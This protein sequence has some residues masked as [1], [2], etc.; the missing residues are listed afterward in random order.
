MRMNQ[1]I[2]AASRRA[3]FKGQT[4]YVVFGSMG[5]ERR[6]YHVAT[7]EELST[8]FAG[9]RPLAVCDHDGHVEFTASAEIARSTG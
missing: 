5:N 3:H 1:A 4:H 9:T 6:T 8:L 7:V 2:T